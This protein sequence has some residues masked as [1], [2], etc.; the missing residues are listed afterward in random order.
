V[1]F[2]VVERWVS[3]RGGHPIVS[4]QVLRLPGLA[5]SIVAIFLVMAVFSGFLFA[6]T[7]HLQE[8]LGDSA[9]R[10]ALT[11]A[12]TGIAFAAVSLSWRRLP[13]R[14]HHAVSIGG[15]AVYA[16]ALLW[17][18]GA[19]RGGGTGG[20]GLQVALILLGAGS[21]A[22]FSPVMTRA[23]VRVPV[24]HAADA[25]GLIVTTIQLAIVTGVA[26]FGTLY[27]NLAARLPAHAHALTDSVRLVSAHA[28]SVTGVVLAAAIAC[29]AVWAALAGRAAREGRAGRAG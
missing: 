12:P 15:F 28:V 9:L 7:L 27:L 3:R 17:L 29:G 5:S 1:V 20:A 8:A 4:G 18:A 24:E 11:F 22:A 23:L 6:L 16:V 25:S 2:A 19:L 13:A 26:A 14:T 10:A 21:A